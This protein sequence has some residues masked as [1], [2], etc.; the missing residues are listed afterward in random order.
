[1]GDKYVT[2]KQLLVSGATVAS[3]LVALFL[4]S[5]QLHAQSPHGKDAASK[6]EVEHLRTFIIEAV[7]EMGYDIRTDIRQLRDQMMRLQTSPMTRGL[8]QDG[9]TRQSRPFYGASEA[10]VRSEER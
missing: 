8:K 2:Y 3:V 1:M 4:G 7:K 10:E 9:R 5:F 6:E